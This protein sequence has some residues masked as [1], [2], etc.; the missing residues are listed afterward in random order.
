M[1]LMPKPNMGEGWVLYFLW[2]GVYYAL[3]LTPWNLAVSKCSSK[4]KQR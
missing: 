1:L 2:K 3:V 4:T